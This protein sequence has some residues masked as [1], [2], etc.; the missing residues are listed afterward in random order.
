MSAALQPPAT[1]A[2]AGQFHVHAASH[3]AGNL[4]QQAALLQAATGSSR[5]AALQAD[6][7]LT[8]FEAGPQKYSEQRQ[9]A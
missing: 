4:A 6:V 9:P 3:T 5:V 8:A 7:H 1:T 2:A